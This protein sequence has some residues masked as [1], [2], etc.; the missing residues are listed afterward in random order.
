VREIELPSCDT[1][2]AVLSD[3][4]GGFPVDHVFEDV[5]PHELAAAR[6][7]SAFAAD[8]PYN[9]LLVRAPNALV[10]VDTGLGAARHPFGGSGGGLWQELAEAGVAA[11]D[12]DIVVVT[13]GHLDHIGG[14][15]NDG[16]PAFPRARYVI[17]EGEWTFWTTASVLDGLSELVATPARE[18]LPPLEAAGVLERFSGEVE[19]TE[20]VR[21]L[22]APGHSPAH[23]AVEIGETGGLLFAVD[24]LLHPLQV[25][26]PEWGRGLDQDPEVAVESRVALLERAARRNHIVTASHWDTDIV[27]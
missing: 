8:V 1:R 20:Q 27:L 6:T 2:C 25:E 9:C 4:R 22:P 16:I 12:V 15:T 19:L 14:L 18:Q 13:H 10:L 21:L 3:G 17:S 23:V 5:P 24:A 11:A 26:H 7:A